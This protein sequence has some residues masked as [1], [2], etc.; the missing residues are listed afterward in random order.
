MRKMK[1]PGEGKVSKPT[2]QM[3]LNPYLKFINKESHKS[4]CP[5]GKSINPKLAK[6]TS[7][8]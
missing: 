8:I 3:P 7:N 6:L 1:K 5:L 4:G 2:N